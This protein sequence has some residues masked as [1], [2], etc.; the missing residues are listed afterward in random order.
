MSPVRQS[1][2]PVK[3]S[4]MRQSSGR[5]GLV[6]TLPSLRQDIIQGRLSPERQNSSKVNLVTPV[7]TLGI[8]FVAVIQ[9]WSLFKGSFTL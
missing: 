3:Q 9:R 5:P 7:N 6:R 1:L 2:G 4:L 8:P